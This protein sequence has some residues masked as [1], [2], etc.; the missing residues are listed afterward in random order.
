MKS[1][2]N[3]YHYQISKCK[4]VEEFLVN[5]QLVENCLENDLFIEIK[6]HRG[7]DVDDEVTIDGEAWQDIAKKFASIYSEQFNREN[8]N[9]NINQPL[10][11]I[12]FNLGNNDLKELQKVNP[13]VVK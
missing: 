7:K 13:N 11:R 2:R 9:D 4:Q 3:K 5:S 12:N 6:K 8:D 10:D 1:T